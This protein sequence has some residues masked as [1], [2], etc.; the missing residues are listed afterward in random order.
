MAENITWEALWAVV[1]VIAAIVACSF[2]IWWRIESRMD[3]AKNDAL[4]KVS[5]VNDKIDEL[6][7]KVEMT[8]AH[9]A[10]HKIEVAQ[11]YAT[12]AGMSEQMNVLAKIVKDVG[13]RLDKRLDG[14]TERLDRVIEARNKLPH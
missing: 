4:E 10:E 13:E 7:S 14:M 1:G 3:W 12:K 6:R 11:K 8:S 9:L 2:A 5:E